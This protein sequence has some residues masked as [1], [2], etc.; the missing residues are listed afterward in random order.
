MNED[1]DFKGRNLLESQRYSDLD[2]KASYANATQ[3]DHKKY[4]WDGCVIQAGRT[5]MGAT[6]P[7]I[8]EKQAGFIPLRSRRPSTPYR[9][10]K[11]MIAA[12]TNML[13]GDKR[14]PKLSCPG[15]DES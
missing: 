7:L 1:S 11:V 2:R 5:G 10:A 8:G 4:N 15:E 3:H 9:L 12:F 6:Q 14:F 13:F